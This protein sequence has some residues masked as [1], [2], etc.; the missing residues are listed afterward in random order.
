MCTFSVRKRKERRKIKTI[1]SKK[2]TIIHRHITP[3]KK[4]DTTAHLIIQ[5]K[6]KFSH[7]KDPH[8]PLK[9]CGRH[10]LTGV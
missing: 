2:P 9:H 5:R 10:I 6:G 8:A 1:A 3:Q 7:R 4:E